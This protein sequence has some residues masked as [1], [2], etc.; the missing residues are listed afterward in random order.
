LSNCP[1]G[2]LSSPQP[3]L[4]PDPDYPEGQTGESFVSLSALIHPDGT[5]HNIE[6]EKSG[7]PAFDT[8]AI[9]VLGRWRFDAGKCNGNPVVTQVNL[10]LHFRRSH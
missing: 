6:V 7:G 8:E 5:L 3:R 10:D 1:P 2:Q 4:T 9:R